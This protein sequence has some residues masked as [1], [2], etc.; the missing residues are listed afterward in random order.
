MVGKHVQTPGW[1]DPLEEE[2]VTHYSILAWKIPWTEKPGSYSP[3]GGKKSRHDA[4]VRTHTHTHII[5]GKK[6]LSDPYYRNQLF[7]C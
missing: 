3:W 7:P 2:I 1:E 4:C 6:V 5:K